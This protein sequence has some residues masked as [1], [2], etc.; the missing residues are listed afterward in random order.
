MGSVASLA[1]WDAG[2]IPSQAQ[3]IKRQGLP[4]LKLRLQLK[5]GADPWPGNPKGHRAAKKKRKK[6]IREGPAS[7]TRR[8]L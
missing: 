7:T 5:F 8:E 6:G 3:W 1:H 2:S 4:Q